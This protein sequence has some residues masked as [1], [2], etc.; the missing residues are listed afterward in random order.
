M[1]YRISHTTKCT[2][3]ESVPVCHNL[4]RLQPRELVNQ[5]C[6]DFKLIIHPE[7]M[8]L[9]HRL[10]E[11]GNHVYYF[12]IEQSHHGLTVTS[13]SQ[14]AVTPTIPPPGDSIAWEQ[15]AHQLQT[16]RTPHLLDA[17]RFVGESAQIKS[18][19]G[20]QDYARKSFVAGRSVVDAV[21]DLTQRI[22]HDFT[23]DVRATTIQT[24]ISEMFEKRR[25]VCQDFAQ[26]HIG[27]I[28]SMGLAAR[29]V[30]GYVRTVPPPGQQR[31][32]GADASHAW[33]SVYCGDAGWLDVD[34]TNN[35]L[36]SDSHITLAWGRD[37]KD[38]CPLQGVIVGGG[39]HRIHIAVD[40]IPVDGD[41]LPAQTQ[42]Q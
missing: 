37:Y 33:P 21:I 36:V 3:S 4:V 25:G 18:F 8:D 6:S 12:S 20:L 15:L 9:S 40:V 35:A 11:F 13:T 24:P 29:Y 26:L 41:V 34:P 32:V 14:V 28:R 2:Y 17:Y 19:D 22:H 38:V 23:F 1:N 30:S 5:N 31:L 10:D 16:E 7:P 42:S 27:C 39:D